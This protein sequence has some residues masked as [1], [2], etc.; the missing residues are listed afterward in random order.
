[1]KIKSILFT[2]ITGFTGLIFFLT[3]ANAQ[4]RM[5]RGTGMDMMSG[6]MVRHRY[7]MRNGIDSEY[8]LK[9]NPLVSSKE[10]LNEGA[11][12]YQTFC[13]TCH[14]VNGR[15]D[16]EAGKAL[17]PPPPNLEVA[18]NRRIATDAFLYWTIAEGG[19]SLK[20]AMLP[21]KNILKEDQIW[22]IVLHLR[23]L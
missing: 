20:T 23:S 4:R 15:G 19:V 12:L 21:F 18:V 16:G 14:G 5:G 17:V 22:K 6:N 7:V 10:N 13:A 1:M 9:K 8:R 3:D 2:A 11:K